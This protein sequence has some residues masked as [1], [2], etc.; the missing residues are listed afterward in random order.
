MLKSWKNH[1]HIFEKVWL[2]IIDIVRIRSSKNLIALSKIQSRN[3]NAWDSDQKW[4]HQSLELVYQIVMIALCLRVPKSCC[5][6]TDVKENRDTYLNQRL[7]KSSTLLDNF[8]LKRLTFKS[9]LIVSICCLKINLNAM[10]HYHK[11]NTD[12]SYP[13]CVVVSW[14]F[15]IFICSL[16]LKTQFSTFV[17]GYN[18][19]GLK[20]F[21]A[22]IL[23]INHRS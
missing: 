22:L 4:Y 6:P 19:H 2:L 18:L 16:L 7:D 3:Q 8:F 20:R 21:L 5:Q 10:H 13:I 12:R 1:P 14:S 23:W 17:F 11:M 9:K 15:R